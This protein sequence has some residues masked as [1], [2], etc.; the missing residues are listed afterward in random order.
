[1]IHNVDTIAGQAYDRD[2]SVPSEGRH[3]IFCLPQ[4]LS[5]SIKS[6]FEAIIANS[7]WASFTVNN[8]I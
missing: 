4:R 1:M 2:L 8:G 7:L 3:L 5:F 6:V